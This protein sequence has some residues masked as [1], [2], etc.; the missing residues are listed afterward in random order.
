MPRMTLYVL[1]TAI[2][3]DMRGAIHAQL[4]PQIPD[5]NDLFGEQGYQDSLR[6]LEAESED[7]DERDVA[8]LLPYIDFQVA[9]EVL[10]RHRARLPMP[11]TTHLKA[12]AS[13]MQALAAIRNR[14]AHSRP[15]EYSDLPVVTALADRLVREDAELWSHLKGAQERLRDNPAFVFEM[16]L[17]KLEERLPNNLPE[18]DFDETG[19]LGRKEV[20]EKVQELCLRGGH[21][22]ITIFGEGGVGKTSLALKVA[23]ELLDRAEAPF[24]SI[25]WATSKTTAL[26][27]TDIVGIEDAIS[28]SLG[29]ISDLAGSIGGT[30]SRDPAAE[31]IEYLREFRLLLVVDNLE[32]V[33]DQRLRDFLADVPAGGSK[34]LLT[35]RIGVGAYEHPVPL[36]PMTDDESVLLLRA[37]A[38]AR[39]VGDLVATDNRRLAKYCRRMKNN[40]LWI[41]WFVSGVQA[42]Q[43]PEALLAKPDR[44]LDYALTN[45]YEY[46][47]EDS[48][49]LLDVM[50]SVPGPHSQ[51]QLAFLSQI[52][53]EPLQKA[54]L[55]LATTHMMR[56]RRSPGVSSFES[57]Y[58]LGDL[59]RVYLSKHHP[60]PKEEDAK[61]RRR[62][63][64]LLSAGEDLREKQRRNPYLAK[65]LD[66]GSAGNLIVAR[67]LLAALEAIKQQH[68]ES[69]EGEIDS[70]MHLAPEWFEVHR[71]AATL[72][73]NKGNYPAAQDKFDAALELAPESAPLRLWYGLFLLNQLSEHERAVAQFATGVKLDPKALNLRLEL[74]RARLY[75]EEFE[76]AR[77][78]IDYVL[79]RSSSLSLFALKK[80][81]DL[82][83]QYY[84]RLSDRLSREG[85]QA[86]AL[87]VLLGM[88][89][90]FER[91][92]PACIDEKILGRLQKA[93]PTA[94]RVVR[95]ATDSRIEE[96]A[97]EVVAWTEEAPTKV[98]APSPRT[99]AG[100]MGVVSALVED[101]EFGF[102]R[103]PEGREVFFHVSDV[104][105]RTSVKSLP[106]G[107][108][109]RFQL[110]PGK[111]GKEKAVAV[112]LAA[113]ASQRE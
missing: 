87:Q 30:E 24:D 12:V 58:A 51:A 14:V 8:V 20:V 74:A 93:T 103:T 112:V 43:R 38:E 78:E 79:E 61:L 17:P 47:S 80:L 109:V 49:K 16:E 60:V 6:R 72:E 67:H 86:G 48:R 64:Q 85:D 99:D 95:Y 88:R 65:S 33:L 27:T 18:P 81:H 102:I 73:A 53:P 82:D 56:I 41:K 39:D 105:G 21:P 83:L 108:H 68:F 10:N 57:R 32:T 3:Q 96:R 97:R 50:Q 104:P 107:T 71:V 91:C 40:P 13:D 1:L 52:D 62:R 90:A 2:E 4:A 66:M 23:Y 46:L 28:D 11:V 5:P 89:R 106:V 19:F 7:A 77:E 94:R 100:P 35:S 92:P 44:F 55:Q 98:A 54:L 63:D 59:A 113:V 29:L 22:V 111:G 45:V 42:G 76:A 36:E 31:V 70:A 9:W 84:M 25:V 34:I 75:V 37:L 15:L 101:S 69:A 26:T 110:A